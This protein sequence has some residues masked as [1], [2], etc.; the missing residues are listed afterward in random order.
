MVESPGKLARRVLDGSEIGRCPIGAKEVGRYFRGKWGAKDEFKG[1]GQ[2]ACMS[3][4]RTKCLA[5]P[6]SEK[7]VILARKLIKNDSAPGPD[8]VVKTDL[9]KW[10]PSGKLLAWIFNGFMVNQKIPDILKSNRTTLI[11]KDKEAE[12]LKDVTNWRPIT[13]GPMVLRLFSAI[14]SKR[15]TKACPINVRQKGFTNAPGCS[16]NLLLVEGVRERSIKTRAPLA[17]VFIDLAKA[18]DSISHVHLR[19]TLVNRRVDPGIVEMINDSYC[20]CSTRVQTDNGYSGRIAIE[21][22][23]KQGDPLSPLLFNLAIDPLLA[24]L[25]EVGDGFDMGDEKLTVMAYADDLVLLSNSWEGMNKNMGVLEAFCN[26]TGLRVNTKKCHGFLVDRN[27]RNGIQ[28]NQCPPW[29]LGGTDINMVKEGE[30]VKYLGIKISPLKGPYKPDVEAQILTMGLQITAANLKPTQRVEIFCSY[31]IPRSFYTAVNN[32]SNQTCLRNADSL[33]RRFIKD[34]LHLKPGT[35][36]GILYSKHQDGGLAIPCLSKMVARC[37]AKR[38]FKLYHSDDKLVAK[39]ARAVITP[40][41]FGKL[42]RAGGGSSQS[43]LVVQEDLTNVESVSYRGP[44]CWRAEEF[45]KWSR[46][47]PQGFG[48][49]LYEKDKISNAWLRRVERAKWRESQFICAIQMRCNMLPTLELRFGPRGR[50]PLCRACGVTSETGSHIMGSCRETNLN[51]MERHNKLCSL[52]AQEGAK[53]KWEVFCERRVTKMDC[54]WAVPDL[55]FV[56]KDTLLVVDITVRLDGSLDWLTKGKIE[57]ETKYKKILGPLQLEFPQVSD[58]S[59]HG[60]VMGTRGKWLG[61]NFLVLEKLGMS[62]TSRLRFA[63]LCSKITILKS[64]DVYQ[65]FNKR[66]RGETPLAYSQ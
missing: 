65:A 2:F 39:V 41:K 49:C 53:K 11:P 22:G 58:L 4:S 15:L 16:E 23:V 21:I 25:Q 19:Q 24:K 28:L 66:V 20:G 27:K 32:S 62:K 63:K 42:W 12:A 6:I 7:E 33:I 10:D 45:R 37:K 13:I 5:I 29:S 57:K 64:V 26:L 43:L 59:A 30:M 14:I 52:L 36:N 56:R 55:I 50:I 18:F 35:C 48:V 1:L 47:N 8:G 60:F 44:E 40:G 31:A 17:M 46:K 3:R 34:W 38:A 61:S 9:I 54:S 51:R